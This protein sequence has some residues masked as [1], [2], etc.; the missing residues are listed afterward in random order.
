[1]VSQAVCLC[2]L[3]S[4]VIV[5]Q[6]VGRWYYHSLL[7]HVSSQGTVQCVKCCP[8]LLAFCQCANLTLSFSVYLG[9]H[10]SPFHSLS[11]CHSS[12]SLVLSHNTVL[13]LFSYFASYFQTILM[14]LSPIFGCFFL[15]FFFFFLCSTIQIFPYP[16]TKTAF[17]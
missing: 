11:F 16:A 4:A 9:F 5:E 3:L 6:Y 14:L 1:M 8:L 13:R 2:M 7:C 12:L 17:Y 10:L 15:F